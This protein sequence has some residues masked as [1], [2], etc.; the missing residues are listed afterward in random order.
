MKKLLAKM[1]CKSFWA[2]L[3]GALALI[4]SRFGFA[5]ASAIAD[6]IVQIAGSIL[7]LCGVAGLPYA[8]PA[9]END[10]NETSPQDNESSVEK[11]NNND[12]Q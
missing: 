2:A 8:P 1:R 12:R 5:N 11:E 10:D 6:G 9:Q 3:S 4:L 7:L